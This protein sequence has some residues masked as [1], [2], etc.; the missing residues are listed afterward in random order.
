MIK[1]KKPFLK[2]LKPLEWK[3]VF[4]FWRRNEAH[5]PNW[6]KVYRERGF[7]S[8]DAWRENYIK[9]FQCDKMEWHFYELINP[10]KNIPSFYGGPFETWKKLYYKV[11]NKY[12]C[13]LRFSEL[14]E[15]SKIQENK[16]INS[17]TDNFPA[18]TIIIGLEVGKKIVV[19]EGMHRSCAIALLA[20][21]K[22]K[23]KS[24]ISIALAKYPENDLPVV[25]KFR[26]SK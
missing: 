3:E 10:E 23:V 9:P 11:G 12:A 22:K 25:G 8:W 14:A 21:R 26:K 16:N 15:L 24:V 18:K 4:G 6:I 19:I 20:K 1:I 2:Y 13:S 17:L 7:D 5:C